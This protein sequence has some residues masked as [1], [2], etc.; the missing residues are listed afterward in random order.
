MS[1][2]DVP[3]L[4]E[5]EIEFTRLFRGL[6]GEELKAMIL[7][8][9]ENSMAHNH[10]LKSHITHKVVA[11]S[12]KLDIVSQ[13]SENSVIHI[14]SRGGCI[15]ID[16]EGKCKE[17]E[18]S[19]PWPGAVYMPLELRS[20]VVDTPDDV[21]EE[22]GI[23]VPVARKKKGLPIDEGKHVKINMD[24]YTGK[25][26]EAPERAVEKPTRPPVD[27]ASRTPVASVQDMV[28]SQLD[29]I[30]NNREHVGIDK[31]KQVKLDKIADILGGGN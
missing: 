18:D 21:R 9:L 12:L 6:N 2:I 1:K 10:R 30:E 31:P 17:I 16:E 28:E 15:V 14:D 22:L 20:E 29:Q 19:L 26:P 13:P 8:R 23:E 27:K 25:P 7:K 5:Q 3:T 11:W 24:A 4:P